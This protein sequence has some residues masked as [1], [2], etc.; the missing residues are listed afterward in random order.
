[1]VLRGYPQENAAA[2]RKK[3]GIQARMNSKK[4]T[5]LLARMR[6]LCPEHS[7]DEKNRC[8]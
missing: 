7:D 3:R 1:M 8:G 2:T 6:S 5:V 4:R